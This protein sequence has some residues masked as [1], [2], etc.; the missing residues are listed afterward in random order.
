[1]FICMFICMFLCGAC[2][3][4][5]ACMCDD[6]KCRTYYIYICASVH[7]CLCAAYVAMPYL[8]LCL[9]TSASEYICVSPCLY[10]C[11]CLCVCLCVTTYLHMCIVCLSVF[12][13]ISVYL[14][15]SVYKCPSTF[16]ALPLCHPQPPLYGIYNSFL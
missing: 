11:F 14:F 8:C 3:C 12:A 13:S 2:M 7:M 15:V 10:L 16:L 5:R 6:V 1:M 9:C 4:A